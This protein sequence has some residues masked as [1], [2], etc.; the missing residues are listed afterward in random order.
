MPCC[1]LSL[2]LLRCAV[3]DFTTTE[4]TVS[5][6]I[7]DELILQLRKDGPNPNNFRLEGP[8]A[9]GGALVLPPYGELT[10][11]LTYTPSALEEPQSCEI[12]LVHPKLGEFVY[13]AKGVGQMPGEMPITQPSA[14]LGHTTSGTIGFRNPFDQPLTLDLH[15][16][17]VRAPNW[18]SWGSTR[19]WTRLASPRL[20]LARLGS[21]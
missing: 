15:L 19:P 12:S 16:E 6:P 5:N 13:S 17:Q 8:K 4:I 3:G 2:P 21:A 7:G 1:L 11:L 14:P 9:T 18:G 20:G 10:V